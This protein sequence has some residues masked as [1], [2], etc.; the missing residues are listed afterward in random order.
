MNKIES[1]KISKSIKNILQK[2]NLLTLSTSKNNQPCSNTAFYVHDKNLNLYIWSEEN[3]THSENLKKN[4]KISVNIFDSHQKFDS[5]L[6]GFQATGTAVPITN[7][8]EL[9]KAGILYIKKF[10]KTLKIVK[11]LLT[12][13]IRY[14]NREFTRYH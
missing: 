10:P 9:I 7:K 2:N 3:T 5:A 8:K 1:N 14:L 4:K 6:K 11:T 12:L 13:I